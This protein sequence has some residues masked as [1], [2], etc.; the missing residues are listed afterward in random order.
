MFKHPVFVIIKA[1]L[2]ILLIL[3]L[4]TSKAHDRHFSSH[5][6]QVYR[7]GVLSF[8]DK[9]TTYRRWQPLANYLSLSIRHANFELVVY[10]NDEM[11]EAVANQEIDFILTQPAQYV[12]LTYR[13]QLSS[14]LA[15]LLNKE[16]GQAV[17]KFGGVIFTRS[18]RD[19]IATL[20]DIKG[21][22]VAAASMTS[23]GAFQMQAYELL[24]EGIRIP[25]DVTLQITGQPQ[26][27]AI[28]A[29]LSGKVDVGF[30]RTGVIEGLS[31]Q[32]L[33]DASKLK[34]INAQ[35]FPNYPF[36]SSSRLYPEWAFAAL[37]H[38]DS[39]I[40]REVASLLLA[41]QPNSQLASLTDSAGFTIAGDYRGID[42]LMRDLR[43]E[44]FD[45]F[46]LTTRDIFDLWFNEILIAF[47]L[48]LAIISSLFFILLKSQKQL[49]QER[50]QLQQAL[51]QIRLFNHAIDQSPES[52]E[53][54]DLQGRIIYMNQT[55]EQ[56]TGYKIE[57]MLGQN[58]RKL[59]SGQTPQSVYKALWDN[60]NRGKIWRGVL[61]NKRKNNQ[62]YPC[63]TIISPV[64]DNQGKTTHYLSIQRDITT[65]L[66]QE[67]RID[68]LLYRDDVTGLANRNK[69][70][71]VMLDALQQYEG[72]A[73]KGCLLMMNIS[74]F[75]F[76]NQI[77]G[78]EVG[79]AVLHIVGE[80]LEQSFK[81]TGTVARL[82]ADQFAVFCENKALFDKTDDWQIMLG[83][84][85]L[86][87]L[88][89]PIEI[90]N[91]IFNLESDIGI[92]ALRTDEAQ[93]SCDQIINHVFSHAELALKKARSNPH[94][95]LE[96]FNPKFL[97][98]TIEKHRLKLALQIGIDR[99][100]LRLFVQPQVNQQHKVVGVECLV[101]WQHPDK[102]LLLPGSFI[103]IAEES[104]LIVQLGNWVLEHSCRLLAK[105]Q[106]ND[107]SIRVAVNISPRQF[108][109]VDFVDQCFYF[110]SDV[111]ANPNGLMIEITE[112]LFLDDF[113]MVVEKMERL[114]KLGIRIS[115]DDFGTGYSSLSYLQHLPIDE[116]KID[117]SF[118]LSMNNEGKERCLVASIYAMAQQLKLQVVAEGI[119]TDDQRNQLRQ[120]G[121]LDMQGF[122]FAKPLDHQ[123]WL[124]NWTHDGNT[125]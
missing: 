101:R 51:N 67:Q 76:I 23:L 27:N 94:Q 20:R 116:L 117:R 121:K 112:S 43:L 64:K 106:S 113:D 32:G 22:K 33:L 40:S 53:I 85:M 91:E 61:H 124:T 110:L 108:G 102:G 39:W 119:E 18:D 89:T 10:H 78:I 83:Q 107:P 38:V 16:S 87:V 84:R 31:D 96:V 11:E 115:I 88:D 13:H 35:R 81:D 34:L 90:Q 77:Q 98:E 28:D 120:F 15:S 4:S 49:S 75:K 73:V 82:T 1:F 5:A 70:I 93:Y 44:P 103:S 56:M 19:D 37:S 58:P 9:E 100:E 118:I 7:L 72:L 63:Q 65:K 12:L 123:D 66:Q 24:Q 54:T 114:K 8:R 25:N 55:F 60:L 47:I 109:Q 17:D 14:P 2:L 45:D 95:S 50:S 21:K 6:T 111:G 74:R 62:V 92:A 46:D 57:E 68:E 48:F 105:I 71:K 99:D 104:A 79:D 41:I 97:S 125:G 29:V 86:A 30:V 26:T 122:L 69:L 36:A 59:Q 3:P 52:I 80:R 42:R